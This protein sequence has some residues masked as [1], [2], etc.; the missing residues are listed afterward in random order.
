MTK[1]EKSNEINELA[2]EICKPDG[3]D[4]SILIEKVSE[5]FVRYMS[6]TEPSDECSTVNIDNQ[7]T[8]DSV[9]L[10]K[11]IS[12]TVN[13][14]DS[15]RYSNQSLL[16]YVGYIIYQTPRR[17][18][19][20]P[21]LR[22]RKL[23]DLPTKKPEPIKQYLKIV[24][25]CNRAGYD[26]TKMNEEKINN[27]CNEL[28]ISRE[29]F[30]S[31]FLAET[32]F[33]TF[34]LTISNDNDEDSELEIISDFNENLMTEYKIWLM[35]WFIWLAREGE[36]KKQWIY[37]MINTNWV[38]NKAFFVEEFPDH[39]NI[40]YSDYAINEIADYID[41]TIIK[42]LNSINNNMSKQNFTPTY[43]KPYNNHLEKYALKI[44]KTD[45]FGNVPKTDADS[46]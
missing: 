13:E 27:I 36:K 43:R 8:V 18:D 16:Q 26:V 28:G 2:E 6:Q 39:T 42:Y 25:A 45:P 44:A 34:S 29:T 30:R 3:G 14:Y 10:F 22:N 46:A 11:T 19:I 15:T 20:F 33:Y 4:R 1:V 35:S 12:K 32:H 38:L 31:I 37:E 7:N 41:T 24:E 17:Y 23:Q 21:R 9:E 5:Y 40:E